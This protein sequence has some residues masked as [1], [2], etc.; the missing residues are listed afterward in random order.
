MTKFDNIC[1]MKKAILI[2]A[3]ALLVS[4]A[5]SAQLVKNSI[6]LRY[7][8]VFGLGT[9]ASYQHILSPD[10]RVELDLGYNSNYEYI[11]NLRQDYNSWALTGLYQWVWPLKSLDENLNWYA[12][13]GARLGFWSSSQKYDSK[14]NNGPFVVAAGDAGIEY[15]LTGGIQFA[16]DVRPELGIYNHG[17]GVSVGF[18]IRYQF[19]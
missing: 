6:G 3:T 5:A 17:S 12:G 18:A 10:K 13:P 4:E 2:L 7:G 14:Y 1:P 11:S 8:T 15:S 9:E 19:R 16:I